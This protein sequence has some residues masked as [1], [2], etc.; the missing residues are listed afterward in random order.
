M[1]KEEFL[2]ELKDFFTEVDWD[3]YKEARVSS[4]TSRLYDYAVSQAPVKR[5]YVKETVIRN[6]SAS[7]RSANHQEMTNTALEI[8]SIYDMNFSQLLVNEPMHKYVYRGKPR[9]KRFQLFVDARQDFVKAILDEYPKT[10]YSTL[11]SFLGYKDHTSIMHLLWYRKGC[12][13]HRTT[14]EYEPKNEQKQSNE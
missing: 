8:C 13:A 11:A 5:I 6:E 9:G 7:S 4:L 14:V 2:K 3:S 1:T 10:T 12:I